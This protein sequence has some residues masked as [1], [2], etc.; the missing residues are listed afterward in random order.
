MDEYKKTLEHALKVS[1][2]DQLREYEIVSQE[3][4]FKRIYIFIYKLLKISLKIILFLGKS[5]LSKEKN[6]IFGYQ[7]YEWILVNDHSGHC[8]DFIDGIINNFSS[9]ESILY[10][11]L[12]HKLLLDSHSVS[13]KINKFENFSFASFVKAIKFS[14]EKKNIFRGLGIWKIPLLFNYVFD[15]ARAI[16]AINLYQKIKFSKHAKLITLSDAHWHQSILTSEFNKRELQTFTLVHGQ[17]SEWHLVCPFISNYILTWG[18]RMSEMVLENCEDL[19]KDRIIE[20]GNTSHADSLDNSESINYN[21]RDI[22]ELVFIS[23]GFDSFE[24]YGY[25]GLKQEIIKFGNLN[26]PKIK[27]S[28]RPRPYNNEEEFISNILIKNNLVNKVSIHSGGNFSQLVNKNRIFVGSISSAIA[29]VFM[30]KGLFIGLHEKMPR[31]I[32]ETMFTYNPDIY[33]DIDELEN[34]VIS[35]SN[36]MLFDQYVSKLITMRSNLSIPIPKEIDRHL[37]KIVSR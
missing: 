14:L 36:K 7:K 25:E 20:I 5:Y 15:Y 30:L 21:Y 32:L 9:K 33:F 26:L 17:P 24:D 19:S 22:N 1:Y 28:I 12:N 11:S 8:E 4:I 34:F 35:L 10:I 37:K 18:T 2:F 23:P 13:R 3:L 29:D 16:E 27:L 6:I 31:N